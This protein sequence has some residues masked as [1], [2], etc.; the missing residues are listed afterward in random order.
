MH[1]LQ[2][3]VAAV[4]VHDER[5]EHE[6]SQVVLPAAFADAAE[7]LAAQSHLH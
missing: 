1:S 7:P 3:Y 6:E 2:G 5:G 4:W